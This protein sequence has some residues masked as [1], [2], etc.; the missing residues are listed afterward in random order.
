MDATVEMIGDTAVLRFERRLAHPVA[1]VWQAVTDPRQMAHWF[2]A[3]IAL[4]TGTELTAGAKLR[5]IFDEQAPIEE[6]ISEGEVLEYDPP[7]VYSFRWN[8]DVL[9]FELV[10][11]GDGCRLY[12]SH[13]LGGG[14]I[15]RLAAARNASGW[16]TCLALLSARLDGRAPQLPSDWL[17]PTR[18]YVEKFGLDQGEVTDDGVRFARDLAWQPAERAWQ[19]LTDGEP[20]E[21]GDT[22]PAPATIDVITAGAITRAESPRLLE[23]EWLHEGTPAGTVR[24]EIVSDGMFGV[25]A[26]LSQ[27]IPDRLA[28]SR[29]AALAAW[30]VRMD[31]F[32]VGLF[33][34][35][36]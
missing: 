27:T 1:K 34:P 28:D 2:P 36:R 17:G 8:A 7:K 29:A 22:P 21:P 11:D 23:Y 20:I 15:G 9:R 32:F 5:F 12:F 18:R 10:P 35:A 16:D 13:T 30:Q 19:W 25:R 31:E 26:E 4:T 14:P 6:K 3:A 33:A 24:W